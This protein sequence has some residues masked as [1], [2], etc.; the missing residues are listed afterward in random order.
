M[1]E[2]RGIHF[3]AQPGVASNDCVGLKLFP[4]QGR[5]Q[6]RMQ[7]Q[8]NNLHFAL[9]GMELRAGSWPVEEALESGLWPAC[10][11]IESGPGK[12]ERGKTLG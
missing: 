11:R 9:D 12:L 3:R 7:P 8:G 6:Q 2:R 10:G 4:A 1:G 5:R